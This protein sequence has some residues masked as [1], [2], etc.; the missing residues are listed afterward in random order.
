MQTEQLT[1]VVVMRFDGSNLVLLQ[2]GQTHDKELNLLLILI[3]H[4]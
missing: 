2:R 4:K 1:L 3:K